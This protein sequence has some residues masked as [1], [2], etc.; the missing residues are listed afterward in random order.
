MRRALLLSIS[1]LVL[2]MVSCSGAPAGRTQEL[3]G[4]PGEESE[5]ARKPKAKSSGSSRKSSEFPSLSLDFLFSGKGSTEKNTEDQRNIVSMEED[6]VV[7]AERKK[8]EEEARKKAEEDA[9][10]VAEERKIMEAEFAKN[11]PPPEPPQIDFQFIGYYGPSGGHIG[12]FR[13]SGKEEELIL[14]RKGD[15]I[16]KKFRIVEIGYESAEIGFEG[17]EETKIIPLAAGGK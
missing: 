7:V 11:P 9:K 10:R 2:L 3:K 5:P 1:L 13:R 16:D 6:P 12:V 14:K 17:F 15:M 8:K 4:F